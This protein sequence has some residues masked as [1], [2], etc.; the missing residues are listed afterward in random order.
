MLPLSSNPVVSVHR[1]MLFHDGLDMVCSI[2]L[3]TGQAWEVRGEYAEDAWAGWTAY[4]KNKQHDQF[5]VQVPRAI[6]N[7]LKHI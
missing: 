7:K 6:I 5:K 3:E 2:E 4:L 1:V